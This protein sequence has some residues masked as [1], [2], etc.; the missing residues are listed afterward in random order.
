MTLKEKAES[1]KRKSVSVKSVETASDAAGADTA[2]AKKAPRKAPVKRVAKKAP[3]KKAATKKTTKS[4]KKAPEETVQP[5]LMDIITDMASDAV[6]VEEVVLEEVEAIV[7]PILEPEKK[8]EEKVEVK[9][10]EPKKAAVKAAK[11]EKKVESDVKTASKKTEKVEKK[12]TKKATKKATKKVVLLT[13][14]EIEA[15]AALASRAKLAKKSADE[16]NA[17]INLS[18]RSKAD[19]AI[20]AKNYSKPKPFAGSHQSAAQVK[21]RVAIIAQE[22][23]AG[24]KVFRGIE[25]IPGEDYA[26]TVKAAQANAA[27]DS[28]AALAAKVYGHG[29]AQANLSARSKAA[30]AQYIQES[31]HQDAAQVAA[32]VETNQVEAEVGAEVFR[33]I[34][35]VKGTPYTKVTPAM[36]SRIELAKK[37]VA[38]NNAQVNLS[39]RSKEAAAKDAKNYKKPAPK[40]VAP[41]TAQDQIIS[42]IMKEAK[43]GSRIKNLIAE[44]P[45]VA[46]EKVLQEVKEKAAM[47]SRKELAARKKTTLSQKT[48]MTTEEENKFYDTLDDQTLI[49]MLN[50]LG[51]H[52]DYDT[53]KADLEKSPDVDSQ[54]DKY[55][56]Q[57]TKEGQEYTFEKD[58]FDTKVIPYLCNKIAATLPSK[59]VDNVSL[60]KKINS[61]VTRM[62]I[63]DSANDTAIYNDLFEDMRK[64]LMHAQQNQLYTLEEVEHDIPADLNKLVDRFM[65]VAYTILP[66]WQYNDVKYYEGF[67]YSVMAQFDD[68]ASW[69]N[70]A[71]M[72]IADLYIK[73]GDYK[74]GDDGYGYVLRENQLKDQ[75][76]YRFAKVYEPFDLQRAKGIAQDALRIIDGRY[77]YY[78]KIIEILQK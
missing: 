20:A 29:G 25:A 77:T 32:G 70:R 75:I 35:E 44:V 18:A 8:S 78:P 42:D 15:A 27:L 49:D 26:D 28:R 74:R 36:A 12:T 7:E 10:A 13:P 64:V 33:G 54:V 62:L 67:L 63:N 30:I 1:K 45:G 22:A 55:L 37:S 41:K 3:A 59:T 56:N 17:Q 51:V 71:L 23:Q 72:D 34:E 47:E 60:A 14:A 39:A 58:G 11:A 19:A 9:K 52:I 68:L 40:K 43:N 57:V 53:L 65:T 21:A 50:A 66:G 46:Y 73:H 2:T 6:A 76:Y 4:P 5:T 69:Q 48:T 38:E 16:N 31:S 61:D 24:A